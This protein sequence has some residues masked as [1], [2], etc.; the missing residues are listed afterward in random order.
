MTKKYKLIAVGG[1]FDFFHK[2]HRNLFK[3]AFS[4]SE[5]VIVGITSDNYVLINKI[6]HVENFKKRKEIIKKFLY[7]KGFVNRFK[8]IKLDDRFG[9]TVNSKII[10]SI[11]VSNCTLKTAE[12]INKKRTF[13]Q[14][15]KLAIVVVD[16]SFAED[17]LLISSKRIRDG[18]INRE[19]KTY[20]NKEWLNKN[21]ILPQ[22][23]RSVLKKPFGEII[24]ERTLINSKFNIAT[25]GDITTQK[26]NKLYGNQKISIIDFYVG[27]KKIFSDIKQLKFK[28][29]KELVMVPNP[30]GMITPKLFIEIQKSLVSDCKKIILVQGEEDL[31]VLPLIILAP[32]NF[33]IFYGLPGKGLV[34]VEINESTKKKAFSLLSRFT[35]K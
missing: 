3:K 23:L 33:L 22:S 14:L 16:Y 30:P 4:V 7:K 20:F 17:G 26:F 15:P 18:Q 29:K 34:R 25:V 9:E 28:N 5:K 21:L 8:I 10:D 35:L 12:L 2:G 24:K 27:R 11:I 31:A 32:L 6:G 19:G 1:T 13:K